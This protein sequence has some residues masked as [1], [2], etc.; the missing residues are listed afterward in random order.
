MTV[1]AETHQVEFDGHCLAYRVSG[2][3]SAL[4]LLN[5]YRRRADMV[6][7][8]VLSTK[9]R[10][11]Q[12][13]P[14]GYGYSERVPGF[15]GERLVDQV[16][17]VLDRHEVDRFVVWGYS[18]GGAMGLGIARATRRAAGVVCGGFW[19]GLVTPGLVRQMDRRLRPDHPSRSLW[20]WFKD[21]D[22]ADELSRMSCARLLYWGS[23][24]RQMAQRLRRTREQLT[25][26]DVDFMEFPG[27]DHGGC[28]SPE[29][30][31]SA[32]V[33]GVAGWLER[34]LGAEW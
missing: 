3:G 2:Q 34:R 30:L 19:P 14:L 33:P 15:A 12:V 22:W 10:V 9:L 16:L 23:E 21:F 26:Q 6:Q 29:A 25:L 5:L 11:F 4:V 17:A 24:D 32:V 20:W 1:V 7:A 8:R 31:E 18:K 28:S 13:F 27:F